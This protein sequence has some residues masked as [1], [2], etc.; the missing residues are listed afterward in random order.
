MEGKIFHK[1]VNITVPNTSTAGTYQATTKLDQNYDN[2][3]GV[4]VIPVSGS[5]D[6]EV[7]L[8]LAADNINVAPVRQEFYAFDSSCP[9]NARV[10]A[11]SG[12]AKGNDVTISTKISATL[13][14]DLNYQIIFTLSKPC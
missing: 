1:V 8:N 11:L 7:G 3:L 6:F 4:S 10:R 9:M 5:T 14:A 12:T 2:L 13:A